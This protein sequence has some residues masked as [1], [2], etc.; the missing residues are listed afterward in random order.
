MMAV[1]LQVIGQCGGFWYTW[2]D[3]EL[4]A[5]GVTRVSWDG[6]APFGWVPSTVNL[7]AGSTLLMWSGKFL[8]VSLFL[9][10]PCVIHKPVPCPGGLIAELYGTPELYG[11]DYFLIPQVLDWALPNTQWSYSS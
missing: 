6:M 2:K 1:P 10:D 7:I 9:D 4:S 3:K 8:F 5:N 11:T